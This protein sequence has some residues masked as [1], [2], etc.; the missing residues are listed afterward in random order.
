MQKAILI[1]LIITI[2]VCRSQAQVHKK[3]PIAKTAAVSSPRQDQKAKDAIVAL[4]KLESTIESGVGL[5]DYS[6]A[7][8]EANFPIKV[9]LS[10]DSAANFPELSASIED[11]VKWYR[12]ARS[13]WSHGV[14]EDY[15]IGYCSEWTT[16]PPPGQKIALLDRPQFQDMAR[17]S[18]ELCNAFP[19][20]VTIES[21]TRYLGPS[22]KNVTEDRKII[23]FNDAQQTAWRLGSAALQ[24]AENLMK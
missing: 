24:H 3:T 11:T 18:T 8:A 20:L 6:K 4:E 17:M 14:A 13:V 1:T 16:P 15:P 21:D 5:Q 22:A 12:A 23:R 2:T 19:E 7:L 10:G 9:F